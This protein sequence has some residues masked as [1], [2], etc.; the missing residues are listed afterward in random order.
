MGA[1]VS[2]DGCIELFLGRV[3]VALQLVPRGR[4]IFTQQQGF[5]DRASLVVIL[6]SDRQAS[7]Q[8]L[9]ANLVRRSAGNT[10]ERFGQT[11]L[12]TELIVDIGEQFQAL[13]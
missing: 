11:L 5:D 4:V 9:G 8:N 1:G 13:Q 7:Q 10:F 6:A 12:V 3:H 2:L